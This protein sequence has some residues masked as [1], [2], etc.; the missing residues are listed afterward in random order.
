[1]TLTP[2]AEPVGAPTRPAPLL[3]IIS[4][5]GPGLL[6]S[7]SHAYGGVEEKHYR[8]GYTNSL[9]AG[10]DHAPERQIE[11][12]DQLLSAPPKKAAKCGGV[13]YRSPAKETA[14]AAGAKELEIIHPPATVAEERDCALDRRVRALPSPCTWGRDGI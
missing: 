7:V 8:R 14:N 12:G 2:R 10:T 5:L 13:W 11:N 9:P 6:L 4:H 1:M 3:R